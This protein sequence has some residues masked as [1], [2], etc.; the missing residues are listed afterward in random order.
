MRKSVK[1]IISIKKEVEDI[2]TRVSRSEEVELIRKEPKERLKVNEMLMALLLKL[3][4]VRGVDSGVRD[5]RKTVIKKAIALQERVDAIASSSFGNYHPI[6]I[7]NESLAAVSAVGNSVR[8]SPNSDVV[9]LENGSGQGQEDKNKYG[10]DKELLIEEKCL[11]DA[12]ALNCEEED[13]GVDS[14]MIAEEVNF[15]E[16]A[17][18][19]EVGVDLGMKVDE[20]TCVEKEMLVNVEMKYSSEVQV[21][22]LM[23]DNWEEMC[24]KTPTLSECAEET[25]ET[26]Q[27]EDG[28]GGAEENDARSASGVEGRNDGG[29]DIKRNRQLLERMMDENEKMMKLITQLYERNEVQTQMLNTLT[30]RVEQL[31]KVFLLDEVKRKKKR[32]CA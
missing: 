32:H 30:Q 19:G 3:D 25:L 12:E 2:E 5:C 7:E 31:E 9:D 15:I 27:M 23:E 18:K 6:K 17:V 10:N 28:T 24:E 16:D 13:V 29:N 21:D 4:S 11:K 14:E 22:S 8:I 1:K 20:K 26:S